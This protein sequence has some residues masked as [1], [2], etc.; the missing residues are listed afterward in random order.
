MYM[1]VS[2]SMYIHFITWH[3]TTAH[4]D[5]PLYIVHAYL[6]IYIIIYII[7]FD[8]E[9]G[10]DDYNIII[11]GPTHVISYSSYMSIYML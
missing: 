5:S 8:S 1:L 10:K 7:E 4:L 11:S 6:H 2:C 3:V 9:H